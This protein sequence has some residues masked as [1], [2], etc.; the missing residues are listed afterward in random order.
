MVPVLT[1]FVFATSGFRI[2]WKKFCADGK[3]IID[4]WEYMDQL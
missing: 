1:E 3:L 2:W 4:Y